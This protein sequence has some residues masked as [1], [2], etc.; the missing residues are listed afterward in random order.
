M[1]SRPSQALSF[2]VMAAQHLHEDARASGGERP[3]QSERHPAIG[4][5]DVRAAPAVGG[6]VEVQERNPA[7]IEH[8]TRLL[9]D[10]GP[11]TDLGE[12]TVEV[13]EQLG[14]TVRHAVTLRP[15]R[16][17]RAMSPVAH[18]SAG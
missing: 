9:H 4:G 6:P 17:A 7:R 18:A 10:P 12:E 15:D 5:L 11:S 3:R 8:T 1:A 16:G 13:V 2:V 14:R